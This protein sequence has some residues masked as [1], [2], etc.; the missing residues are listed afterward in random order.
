MITES[1]LTMN[2]AI[3][4]ISKVCK[5]T[6]SNF[7]ILIVNQIMISFIRNKRICILRHNT[8]AAKG[9]EIYLTKLRLS[10]LTLSDQHRFKMWHCSSWQPIKTRTQGKRKKTYMSTIAFS[11][12]AAWPARGSQHLQGFLSHFQHF[13]VFDF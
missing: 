13:L 5:A 1:A 6:N 8:G 10:V 4:C 12:D 3:L 2:Y 7:G 11:T 9:Y